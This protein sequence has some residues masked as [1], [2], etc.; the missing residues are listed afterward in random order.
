MVALSQIWSLAISYWFIS[1]LKYIGV[2]GMTGYVKMSTRTYLKLRTVEFLLNFIMSAIW[3]YILV[4]TLPILTLPTDGNMGFGNMEGIHIYPFK[5]NLFW[6]LIPWRLDQLAGVYDDIS[7]RS[8]LSSCLTEP[9][10]WMTE[11]DGR[12]VEYWLSDGTFPS[13]RQQEA[14]TT[15]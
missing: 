15:E 3:S 5:L 4:I 14:K 11:R 7:P 1:W 10:L 13:G 12:M 2:D 9:K 6:V 8:I